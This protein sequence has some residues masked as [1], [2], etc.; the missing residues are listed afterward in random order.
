MNIQQMQSL[1]QL[2]MSISEIKQ[3][4][5]EELP[6]YSHQALYFNNNEITTG[7]LNNK[8][9][10]KIHLL[11]G[12][13]LFFNDEKGHYVDLYT[14][15]L[16]EKLYNI[17]EIYGIKLPETK[18]ENLNFEKI[19]SF[20]EYAVPAKQ[21]L[22][23]FRMTLRNNFTLIHLWPHHFDFSVEWFTGNSDEQIGTG[24]SPGDENN[25]EPYLY[26]NPYPFNKKVLEKDLPLGKWNTE[27]WNGVKIEWKDL[28]KYTPQNAANKLHKVFEIVKINFG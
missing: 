19:S 24:I 21:I 9:E 25:S 13:L 23:L 8:I 4:L 15:N 3:Q 18:L 26:M 6:H 20:N 28:L 1:H 17:S 10:I 7:L 5:I 11:T 12:Q 22:E 27:G 2:C 16:F 14:D